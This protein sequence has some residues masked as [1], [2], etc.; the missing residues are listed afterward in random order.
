VL[1]AVVERMDVKQQVF[2]ELRGVVAPE[3]VLATNTSSLSVAEMGADLGMHFFN[4]VAVMPLV[5]LVRTDATDD[6]KLA[7][8]WHVTQA[9]RKRA[10]IVGDTPGFVVNRILTRMTSVLMDALEHGNTIEETDEA[11]L[12]LGMPMAP[13]VLLQMVGPRVAWHT[14]ETMHAAFPDRFPLSPTLRNLAEGRD[15]I[16]VVEER[17]QSVEEI[18]KAALEAVADEVKRLLD[19]GVVAEAAD[20][21]A[22]LLLGA[23]WPFFMGGVTK[24]LDQVGISERLFGRPLADLGMPARASPPGHP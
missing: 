10:V 14:L 11:L 23:G 4:P 15:E 17:P 12:G 22:C 21:D 16:V 13:S 18:R 20:I 19:D 8:A 5:E 6:T 9:L 3:C 1:E 2:A 24:Y 7:T